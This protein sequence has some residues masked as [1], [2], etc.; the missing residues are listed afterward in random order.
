MGLT[1]DESTNEKETYIINEIPLLINE[2][3]RDYT[4][5]NEIDYIE[6]AYGE[7][8]AIGPVTGSACGSCTSC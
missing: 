8:F 3:I 1:L 6:N 5:G 7:G 2:S 4:D